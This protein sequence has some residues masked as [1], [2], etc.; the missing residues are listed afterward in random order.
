MRFGNLRK[1]YFRNQTPDNKS[2]GTFF[3][4]EE[5]IVVPRFVPVFWDNLYLSRGSNLHNISHL[6]MWRPLGES[7]PCCRD[8]NPVS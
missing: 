7:N 3:E 6:E 5:L 8:E 2:V 4:P 1:R